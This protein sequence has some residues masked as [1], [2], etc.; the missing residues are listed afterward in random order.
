MK[1][2]GRRGRRKSVEG[3][4]ARGVE[5][6]FGEEGEGRWK[7]EEWKERGRGRARR[8]ARV[9]RVWLKRGRD[10]WKR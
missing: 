7:K 1:I 9:G 2:V 8:E 10:A 5:V 6:V 3:V 4:A